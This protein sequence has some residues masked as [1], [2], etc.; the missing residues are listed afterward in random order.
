MGVRTAHGGGAPI[1]VETSPGERVCA[2]KIKPKAF[3][4]AEGEAVDLARR[5]TWVDPFYSSKKDYKKLLEEH[6]ARLS[7]AQQLLAAQ[8]T[9]AVLL[10]FQGM[11][12]AGKDGA[13]SHVTSG[14]NPQGCEV[15]SFKQPSAEELRH[16]FL[17]RAVVHL[18]ERGRIGIFNRSYYEEVLV[19]RV[20]PELLEAQHLP[21]HARAEP[22]IWRHR[23]RSIVEL[24][25]HL[26]R[27]GIVIVK[28]FLHVSADEQRVRL[29][30]RV[31]DPRKNWKLSATDATER[32]LWPQYQNAYEEALAATS[33][34]H[35]P[36]YVVPADDKPNARL[37]ISE[38][39]L[40]TL[41]ALNL[42]YPTVDDRQ[43]RELK[44]VKRLLSES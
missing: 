38:T 4:V 23:Y 7:D 39:I 3:R 26:H 34:E 11:D 31:D 25:G 13:I 10:I 5:P 32:A 40:Q 14:V 42:S 22:E 43:R 8:Q 33:A 20:H 30:A 37:I 12:A 44:K 6:V 1:R 15:F 28:F 36:W 41:E 29:L 16:D 35:A 21:A 2:V 9:H 24:E 17:W 18:P 19:V 27:S